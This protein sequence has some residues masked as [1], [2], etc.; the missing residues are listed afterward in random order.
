MNTYDSSPHLSSPVGE[1]MH[2]SESTWICKVT[3][4]NVI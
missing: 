3:K 4:W 1:G 2:A